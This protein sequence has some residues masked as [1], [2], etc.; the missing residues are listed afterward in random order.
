MLH[1]QVGG[2]NIS[3]DAQHF[4][5]TDTD[6]LNDFKKQEKKKKVAKAGNP[7]ATSSK[8]LC[9]LMSDSGAF[10]GE[11]GYLAKKIDLNVRE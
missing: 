4:F 3:T 2:A 6:L 11:S 5:Q 1:S 10:V 9:L 8:V 7:I